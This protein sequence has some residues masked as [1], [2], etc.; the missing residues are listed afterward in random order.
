VPGATDG[1]L[2]LGGVPESEPHPMSQ[3]SDF[4]LDVVLV[5]TAIEK[6]FASALSA[7]G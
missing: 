1:R 4:S 3:L 7:A 6:Y 5:S 2:G